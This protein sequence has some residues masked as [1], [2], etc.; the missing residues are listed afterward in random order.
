VPE[1]I[2]AADARVLVCRAAQQQRRLGISGDELD[3]AER[4]GMAVAG[5]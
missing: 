3:M 4:F 1:D 2:S 5:L